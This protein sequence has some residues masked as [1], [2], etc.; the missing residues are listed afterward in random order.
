MDAQFFHRINKRFEEVFGIAGVVGAG[1]WYFGQGFAYMLFIIVIKE[2]I[3]LTQRVI[4][5]SD[6]YQGGIAPCIPQS[7]VDRIGCQY[8]THVAYMDIARRC[9]ARSN[10]IP[11]ALFK[12]FFCYYICPVYSFCH[13]VSLQDEGR[14][15]KRY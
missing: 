2:R 10:D 6:I 11:V 3:D 15:I 12:C 9:Y 14:C 4:R 13:D 8:F 5:I 1:A 7:A